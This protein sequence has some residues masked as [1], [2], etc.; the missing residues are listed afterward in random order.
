MES[1]TKLNIKKKVSQSYYEH[2][3]LSPGWGDLPSLNCI[4]FWVVGRNW[5]QPVQGDLA[6]ESCPI[7]EEP[8]DN[9]LD[10]GMVL[11]KTLSIK[12]LS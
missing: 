9:N 12:W 6:A 5:L 1:K 3:I 7:L 8:D 4:I 11:F 10:L 2:T